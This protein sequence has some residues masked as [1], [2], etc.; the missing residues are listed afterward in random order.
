MGFEDESFSLT[1]LSLSPI[2]FF[3]LEIDC[4]QIPKDGLQ[5]L[6][7]RYLLPDTSDL[8]NDS[9]FASIG[10]GWGAEGIAAEIDVRQ[11]F[12][13]AVYPNPQQGDSIELFIDTRDLK[14]TGFNTRFCHHFCFLPEE[15]DGF[16]AGEITHFRTEDAHDLCDPSLLQ[17]K[18]FFKKSAY[19]LQIFIP[20]ECLHSYDPDQFDRLGF[21]Y[22][23][24]RFG[25]PPQH[26]NIISTEYQ[27]DQHPALWSSLRLIS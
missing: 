27:I 8:C 2:N 3:A 16:L 22:R 19:S 15:V 4:H 9:P 7:G 6:G 5:K 13:Q 21:T 18:A 26:F 23:I 1:S 25:Q 20:S 17:V 24:N 14:S 11:A 10:I 12:N